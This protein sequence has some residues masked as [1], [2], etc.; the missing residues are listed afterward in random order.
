MQQIREQYLKVWQAAYDKLNNEQKLAVET[1]EGPVLV[2]AGPG[3]GK[4]D[5]LTVRVGNILLKTDASPHNILCMTFTDSGVIAM[6]ERLER[7][8]GPEAYNVNIQTYHSFCSTVIR[9][10]M[11]YFGDYRDLQPVSEL[12]SAQV[13]RDLIDGLDKEHPLARLKGNKY[14]DE[15]RYKEL[16]K[17]MKQE[18]WLPE[19]IREAFDE[20]KKVISDPVTSPFVYQKRTLNKETNT[21][22]EIGSLKI[23]EINN[24]LEKYSKTVAAAN[25]YDNYNRLMADME[26]YDFQ[27]MILWV[28][29]KFRKHDELLAKYQERFQ[30]VL[31]DEYQ[32]TNG[33]QN[34]LLELLISYWEL[35]NIFIVG[36]DDQSIFRFQG[37]NMNSI[38]DFRQRHNPVEVVLTE[39]YRSNQIILDTAMQ[40]I[41]NNEERLVKKFPHLVKNLREAR[42]EKL[43]ENP[44][45]EILR[46]ANEMQEEADIIRR[47]LALRDAGVN[48]NEVAI[49][50]T[51]HNLAE[52]LIRYFMQKKIPVNVKKRVNVLF[53]NDVVRLCK[54]LE[55]ISSEYQKPHS[56]EDLFEI[57]HYDFFGITPLDVAAVSVFV[58]SVTKNE[59]GYPSPRVRWREV[60][61]DPE[62]LSRAG[63]K[64]ILKV[65]KV[66]A[67]V[68]SWIG[69]IPNLTIQTLIEKIL[70]E[71]GMLNQ[72]LSDPDM[73]WKMQLLGTFYDLIKEETAKSPGMSLAKMVETINFMKETKVEL[74]VTR[75]IFNKAGINFLTAYGAK[76]LEFEHVFMIRC[77]QS[78]WEV[79]K[80]GNREFPLPPTLTSATSENS[81]E[82]DRRLFYVG[83]TRAK[84]YLYISYP[85]S[86]GQEKDQQPSKFVSEIRKAG[87][88]IQPEKVD[89]TLVLSYRS[90]LMKYYSGEVKIIDH[91]LVDRIL[92]NFKIS[93]T[94]LNKFLKCRLAFY[95][96]NLLR[97]PMG[98]N[99]YLGFGNAIHYAMEQFFADINRSSPRSYGQVA[100][101]TG[102]FEKGMEKYK[103]HFT[104]AEYGDLMKYG[105]DTLTQYYD[106]YSKEWL[107]VP[108]YFIE[109]DIKQ[110][111]YNGVP[112]SGKLDRVNIYN[113]YVTVTDYKTG[114]IEKEKTNSY[115]EDKKNQIGG[116]YWRQIMFYRLLLDGDKRNNWN[117]REG[118]ISGMEKDKQSG[119]FKQAII[120]VIAEDLEFVG[121]QLTEAYREIKNH[122]FTPGCGEENCRWCNFVSR[123]MP[124]TLPVGTPDTEEA[125]QEPVFEPGI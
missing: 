62:S 56:G 107:N 46:Y 119:K 102:F 28:L 68:E 55:Y 103:S 33:S 29:E 64:D 60:L 21:Y 27:D 44:E 96:E 42:S 41:D 100:K 69:S 15:G 82:D 91:E 83:M 72:M 66:S 4:T 120:P 57:L 51:K 121:N 71:S 98:R 47:I 10:N 65:S 116:D 54:I 37:A 118:I 40:L 108:E 95:F 109:Y 48:L 16:F 78:A 86:I 84:N 93:V 58:N 13:F 32:D 19:T 35:P 18:H 67:M 74:P 7:Y 1:I 31:V 43:P 73:S 52:N 115:R 49:I 123:N 85:D 25:E 111:E 122:K 104:D 77:I 110:T 80:A 81:D 97:V 124:P 113:G 22:F 26:R 20:Y 8:I 101:L 50:Y 105:S 53:E 12:E 90:E 79:K 39:N 23:R 117:M 36:D 114:T 76:G 75:I 61:A 112:I 89:E 88:E 99:S 5:L 3:T 30:Y 94:S 24:Q 17:L 45:P 59:D 63:V 87:Q 14:Y 92:E 106:V 6:R 9:E 125:D 2:V 38:L 34:E 11:Q 70:N